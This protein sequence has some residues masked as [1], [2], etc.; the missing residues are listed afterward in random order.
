MLPKLFKRFEWRLGALF[1]PMASFLLDILGM[2]F[3]MSKIP[4]TTYDA[5]NLRHFES[6]SDCRFA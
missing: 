6:W 2:N 3:E 5:L 1:V 4:L